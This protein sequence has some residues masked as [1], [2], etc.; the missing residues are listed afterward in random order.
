M[1]FTSFV[2][3]IA[4]LGSG[5]FAF[6]PHEDVTGAARE[7]SPTPI[8][9]PD[10]ATSVAT[11]DTKNFAYLP[12]ELTVAPGTPVRFTNSDT[13]DHTVTAA[14]GSFDSKNMTTGQTW[15]HVFEKAGTYAYV[16]AY[17]RYMK[18]TIFVK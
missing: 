4:V 10:A 2:L 11:V 18:G 15:T 6:V 8:A 14:D 17:H 1:N 9:S 16:C 3:A 7:A 12:L 13:V 5:V